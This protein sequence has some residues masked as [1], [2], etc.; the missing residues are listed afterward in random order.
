MKEKPSR[1]FIFLEKP[2]LNCASSR[3][4]KVSTRLYLENAV[5][6]FCYFVVKCE[7]RFLS[8]SF[9]YILLPMNSVS[10]SE[11]TFI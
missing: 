7:A 10:D 3:N 2:E 1:L 11:S 4:L 8:L 6:S 5:V 9:F